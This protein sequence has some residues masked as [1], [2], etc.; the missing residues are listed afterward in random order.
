MTLSRGLG[1]VSRW[2]LGL[3]GGAGLG[4]TYLGLRTTLDD[5][6]DLY[7]VGAARCV[8]CHECGLSY[9]GYLS[10]LDNG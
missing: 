4:A 10:G 3:L 6:F 1:S 5:D 8:Q 9:A 7:N 2:R